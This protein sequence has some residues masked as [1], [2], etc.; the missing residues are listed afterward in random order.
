MSGRCRVLV[1]SPERGV[2][3]SLVGGSVEVVWLPLL[4][5]RVVEG[6]VIAFSLDDCP[7]VGFTSP[8]A[9][10]AVYS[11]PGAWPRV[12]SKMVAAVGPY[13]AERLRS[14]GVEAWL[15]PHRHTVRDLVEGVLGSG[16]QCISLARSRASRPLGIR[17]VREYRVYEPI[18]K[19]DSLR[20]AARMMVDV[21][22][23]TSSLIAMEYCRAVAEEGGSGPPIIV[24]IGP[25]T[26]KTV[27]EA[28]KRPA[29]VIVAGRHDR[30][31][32][33]GAV[34][35]ACRGLALEGSPPLS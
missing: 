16:A 1:L 22:V 15:V 19:G 14:R 30:N 12:A 20:G 32:L 18:V 31:G 33:K 28:C 24:S 35:L 34:E 8:R 9:V 10:D 17:G 11:V 27:F 7:Y 29:L 6:E 23:L 21:A 3:E 25:E 13:T 26:A 2:A 4:E 5:F